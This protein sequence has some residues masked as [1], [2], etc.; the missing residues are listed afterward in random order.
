MKTFL[1]LAASALLAIPALAD[2]FSSGGFT[3]VTTSDTTVEL[4]A[5]DVTEGE[6][7]IPATVT[8]DSGKTYTVTSIGTRVFYDKRAIT[9]VSMPNTV[10]SIGSEA[11]KFC[12]KMEKAQL[13]ENLETIGANAFQTTRALAEINWPATLKSIKTYAFQYSTSY[14]GQIRLPKGIS[15]DDYAFISMGKVTSLWLDGQPSEW[16]VRQCEGCEM[17]TE[18]YVNCLYP[19]LFDP[20]MTFSVDEDG[21][22]DPI[23]MTLYVPIGA[24][25]NYL[26]DEKWSARFSDIQEYE[27]T[28]TDTTNPKGDTPGPNVREYETYTDTW[29]E[30]FTS[31]KLNVPEAGKL[32]EILGE[33]TQTLKELVLSGKLNGDDI[34]WLRQ[35]AGTD[36]AGSPIDGAILETLD[37]TNCEIVPGGGPYFS[38]MQTLYTKQDA[39]G[40]KMFAYCYS[41]KSFSMPKYAQTIGANAFEKSK[42][43]SIFNCNASLKSI[44]ELAFYDCLSLESIDLPDCCSAFADMVFYTCAGLKSVHLPAS[45]TSLPMGTFYSCTSL[46]EITLPSGIKNIEDLAFQNCTSLQTVHLPAATYKIG[47][48]AFG[49]C[50][51]LTDIT[52]EAGNMD[53]SD[54]D[55]VLFNKNKSQLILYPCARESERYEVP[56]GTVIIGENALQNALFKELVIPEGVT[57][58]MP[59]SAYGCKQLETVEMPATLTT[60]DKAFD[61]CTALRD[62]VVAD[63]NTKYSDIEGVLCDS[64]KATLLK[65]PL[66][67][68]DEAYIVPTPVIEIGEEAFSYSQ[69][70]SVTLSEGVTTV[71]VN[72]FALCSNLEAATF[73]ASLTLLR[74]G[75]FGA[76]AL[77]EVHCAATVPPMCEYSEDEDGISHP[78][79]G[80]DIAQCKLYVPEESLPS[81]LEANVWCKFNIEG[82]TGIEAVSEDINLKGAT[83]YTVDGQR[84]A[85]DAKGLIIVQSAD[86]RVYKTIRR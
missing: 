54:I 8:D 23:E 49:Y 71:G 32:N 6:V 5:A 16:G 48:S 79:A 84:A 41:L 73:P 74:E 18:F 15:L 21:W 69:L 51:S 22:D 76:T 43:L 45:L 31:A 25:E 38:Y 42:N 70:K 50:L 56:T 52:V 66:G 64:S 85:A 27:F 2:S 26:A 59:G 39:V 55:G 63:G 81:Y 72:A 75:S 10:I 37:L 80:V 61:S 29:S 68:T 30:D 36:I 53:F 33:H 62:Y 1:P 86:G 7:M 35:M 4:S 78:F 65:Y 46:P 28:G 19:P 57:A 34:L 77:K 83:Y 20:S 67:R 40:P 47:T 58:M 14:A 44:G 13:S 3:F 60:I 82:V 24:K 12:M 9:S 17:L 11:F